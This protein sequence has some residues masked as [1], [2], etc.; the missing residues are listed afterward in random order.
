MISDGARPR[1]YTQSRVHR[2]QIH[3][4]TLRKRRRLPFPPLPLPTQNQ[5]EKHGR[6]P[7]ETQAY[8]LSSSESEVLPQQQ[9]QLRPTSHVTSADTTEPAW[10]S[11]ARGGSGRSSQWGRCGWSLTERWSKRG[12]RRQFLLQ[13]YTPVRAVAPALSPEPSNPALP[14]DYFCIRH[15]SPTSSL[16]V[17]GKQGF[18]RLSGSSLGVSHYYPNQLSSTGVIIWEWK[19]HL[20]RQTYVSNLRWPKPWDCKGHTG[21]PETC[22]P[23]LRKCLP[24]QKMSAAFINFALNLEWLMLFPEICCKLRFH[25]VPKLSPSGDKWH[26]R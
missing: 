5:E 3:S 13:S 22:L 20:W 15:E 7:R 18:C 16:G 4:I 1:P 9:P 17:S 26:H 6:T 25:L 21:I 11:G 14:H 12:E 24:S 19:M 23:S 8:C 10:G 2:G